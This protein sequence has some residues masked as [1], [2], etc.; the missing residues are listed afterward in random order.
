MNMVA[1]GTQYT[2]TASAG[3]GGTITP[4]GAVQVN[5]GANQSFNI[6]AN[7]G[8]NISQVTVDS[9][10]QG[11][12]STYTFNNVQA[13][14]TISATFTPITYTITASAEA[15]EQSLRPAL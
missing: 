1:G 15:T 8:Y 3:T 4:S 5:Q 12:I 14:H 6:S 2:I 7:T 13:N 9:V 10:N 11:A